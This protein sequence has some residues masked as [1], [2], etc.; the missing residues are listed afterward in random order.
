MLRDRTGRGWWASK[1]W[2]SGQPRRQDSYR[3][4]SALANQALSGRAAVIEDFRVFKHPA[5]HRVWVLQI[6]GDYVGRIDQDV[7]R[8]HEALGDGEA[9]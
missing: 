4:S 7:D 3:S 2:G 6:F 1:E 9:D 5:D 8:Q